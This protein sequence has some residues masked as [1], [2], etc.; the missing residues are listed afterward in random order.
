MPDSRFGRVPLY[1]AAEESH[2]AVVKTLLAREDV[3]PNM[4]DSIFGQTP[5]CCAARDGNDAVVKTLLAREDVNPNTADT[6][7]G[8]TP[9]LWAAKNGH[10]EVVKRI[11]ER[12]DIHIGTSD[13][14]HETPLT[15]AFSNGHFE[16]VIMLQERIDSSSE[17][18]DDGGHALSSLSAGQECA[19]VMQSGSGDLDPEI[20]DLDRQNANS[21]GDPDEKERILDFKNAGSSSGESHPPSTE[22]SGPPPPSPECSLSSSPRKTDTS[23]HDSGPTIP[24]AINRYLMISSFVCLFAFLLY[25][26]PSLLPTISPFH[27]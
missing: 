3:N 18:A 14:E 2:D 1:W 26:L 23:P 22:H 10:A 17:T 9:L 11:L 5:L 16:V 27:K 6:R 19:V 21:S 20:T 8:R 4:P 15:S 12:V 25:L 13:N 24:I 7:Y